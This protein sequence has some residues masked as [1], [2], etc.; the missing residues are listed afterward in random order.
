MLK[1]LTLWLASGTEA[2]AALIIALAA[3]EAT[4]RSLAVFVRRSAREPSEVDAGAHDAK[5]EIRL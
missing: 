3:I 1:Q 4:L 2:A 5:E